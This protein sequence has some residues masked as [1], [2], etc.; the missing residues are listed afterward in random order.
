MACHGVRLVEVGDEDGQRLDNFLVTL[1]KGV[2][3]SRVYRMLRRGEVRVNGGR[4]KPSYRVRRGDVVRVPPHRGAARPEHAGA[5]PKRIETAILERV[6]YEDD[7]LLVIDKPPGLAA[8]GGSGVSFGVIEALRRLD[9]H[10]RYEL[11]HRLDRDTS[12]CL[13]VAKRR[14]ALRSLHA[15]FRSGNVH[16]RYDLVVAGRWPE[17]RGSVREPLKRFTMPNGERRV[18][19]DP[20]GDPARTDFEVVA[21]LADPAGGDA[22]WLAAA[23]RT[24]RTHQIR[25]HAAAAGHPILGDAKYAADSRGRL[26]LHATAL[27]L[28][29]PD[30]VVQAAAPLPAE[31]EHVRGGRQTRGRSPSGRAD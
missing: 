16:K 29:L 8:H 6:V 20:G 5:V 31:F 23:P 11:A 12:G 17:G 9:P 30:R 15:A 1:V 14:A 13:A 2:P 4:A 28:P 25:V 10:A 7:D 24:G 19:V 22:T 26:M 27:T 3:K 18:R 21:R